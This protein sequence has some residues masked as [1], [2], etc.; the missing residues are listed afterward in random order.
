MRMLKA[1]VTVMLLVGLL[2]WGAYAAAG[3][4]HARTHPAEAS[5]LHRIETTAG[6]GVRIAAPGQTK[7]LAPKRCRVA[8]LPGF[9]CAQVV[10]IL[11]TPSQPECDLG[12]CARQLEPVMR[13]PGLSHSPPR[14]PPRSF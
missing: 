9:G 12:A 2:P 10:A 5:G 6:I 13:L 11:P 7:V 3:A 1:L 4:A 14:D 8:T